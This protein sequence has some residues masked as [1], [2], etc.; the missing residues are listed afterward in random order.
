VDLPNQPFGYRAAVVQIAVHE[1]ERFTVVQ[2]LSHVVG[3]GIHNRLACEQPLGL[4]QREACAFDVRRVM[5]FQQQRSGAHRREPVLGEFGGVEKPARP[6]DTRQP[7]G[8]G[9]GDAKMG[10]EST[11]VY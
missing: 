6:L 11:A 5:R 4:F 1:L 2:Q 8:H 7:S 9:V 10:L 3:I